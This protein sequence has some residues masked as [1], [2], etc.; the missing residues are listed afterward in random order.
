MIDYQSLI[1]LLNSPADIRPPS[2]VLLPRILSVLMQDCPFPTSASFVTP[3]ERKFFAELMF[4]CSCQLLNIAGLGNG[5]AFS[6]AVLDEA[7]VL[8]HLLA[9]CCLFCRKKL[10]IGVLGC[11][12]QFLA[13]NMVRS[14]HP[15]QDDE[16]GPDMH[17]V[18][19]LV[20]HPDSVVEYADF[21]NL[22]PSLLLLFRASYCYRTHKF[23][24]PTDPSIASEVVA[25]VVSAAAKSTHSEVGLAVCL[26]FSRHCILQS[27]SFEIRAAFAEKVGELCV[28]AVQE[29]DA[30][31]ARRLSVIASLVG[32]VSLDHLL[33]RAFYDP[34]G[35]DPASFHFSS[36]SKLISGVVHIVMIPDTSSSRN[37]FFAPYRDVIAFD[38][39]RIIESHFPRS[40]IESGALNDIEESIFTILLSVGVRAQ[41]SDLCNAACRVFS[42]AR[43]YRVWNRSSPTKLLLTPEALSATDASTQRA[44]LNAVTDAIAGGLV[45]RRDYPRLIQLLHS[46]SPRVRRM[47]VDKIWYLSE[48]RSDLPDASIRPILHTDDA[49]RGLIVC[50]RR[51][52]DDI[53]CEDDPR[54]AVYVLC[55][56]ILMRSSSLDLHR[57]LH[58]S[59]KELFSIFNDSLGSSPDDT[60]VL[61][62]LLVLCQLY[63]SESA[64]A[65][66]TFME[67]CIHCLSSRPSRELITLLVHV[68]AL[69]R[70]SSA[71]LF[72]HCGGL[73]V[74]LSAI[75]LKIHDFSFCIRSFALLSLVIFDSSEAIN[76]TDRLLRLR[77]KAPYEW[78]A[79]M[80]DRSGIMRNSQTALECIHLLSWMLAVSLGFS[81]LSQ[82]LQLSDELA[83]GRPDDDAASLSD[84]VMHWT[85][86]IRE[87][88]DDNS[89]YDNGLVAD[90]LAGLQGGCK[91]RLVIPHLIAT[92]AECSVH[93][94]LQCPDPYLSS[95]YLSSTIEILMSALHPIQIEIVARSRLSDVLVSRLLPIV[96]F[97]VPSLADRLTESGVQ[98]Q[99][100]ALFSRFGRLYFPSDAFHALFSCLLASSMFPMPLLSTIQELMSSPS[101]RVLRFVDA[102]S[103]KVS[104]SYSRHLVSISRDNIWKMVGREDKSR[105]KSMIRVLDGMVFPPPPSNGWAFDCHLCLPRHEGRWMILS[106]VNEHGKREDFCSVAVSV[107]RTA[108]GTMSLVFL[109]NVGK[110]MM[111]HRPNE[112]SFSAK[113]ALPPS[114]D[115]LY[116]ESWVHLCVS[117]HGPDARVLK[118]L[119]KNQL[120]EAETD[121]GFLAVHLDGKPLP[122]VAIPY[123]TVHS[124]RFWGYTSTTI[125]SIGCGAVGIP[126]S[127]AR[128]YDYVLTPLECC[129]LNWIG[130]SYRGSF[131]AH[132]LL[133]ALSTHNL[134]ND[135]LRILVSEEKFPWTPPFVGWLSVLD[136]P[137]VSLSEKLSLWI[138]DTGSVLRRLTLPNAS[139]SE[140]GNTSQGVPSSPSKNLEKASSAAKVSQGSEKESK[141]SG[142]PSRSMLQQW[143]TIPAV[144]SPV[145]RKIVRRPLP[146]QIRADHVV[147]LI[148][149]TT[150]V[151]RLT[152]ILKLVSA[153][154][155]HRSSFSREWHEVQGDAVLNVILGERFA[156]QCSPAFVDALWDYCSGDPLAFRLVM[157]SSNLWKRCS[158]STTKYHLDRLSRLVLSFKSDPF[159]L[160]Q[161]VESDSF[162]SFISMIVEWHYF[163]PVVADV[164]VPDIVN[165]VASVLS[166][167]EVTTTL[168]GVPSIPLHMLALLCSIADIA[169][170]FFAVV[171]EFYSRYEP[172]SWVAALRERPEDDGNARCPALMNY[173]W[174]SL[175]RMKVL[176]MIHVGRSCKRFQEECERLAIFDHIIHVYATAIQECEAPDV[177]MFAQMMF[178]P[179]VSSQYLPFSSMHLYRE[180]PMYSSFPSNA[181]ITFGLDVPS[182][183]DIVLR[184]LRSIENHQ[185]L[186]MLVSLLPICRDRTLAQKILEILRQTLRI[187]A[188]SVV[189]VS[190]TPVDSSFFVSAASAKPILEAFCDIAF[191]STVVNG[192]FSMAFPSSAE[193]TLRSTAV[194]FLSELSEYLIRIACSLDAVESE[195]SKSIETLEAVLDLISSHK[196]AMQPLEA[197]EIILSNILSSL[198][199]RLSSLMGTTD[200]SSSDAGSVPEMGISVG[201]FASSL[202]SH[203]QFL[204]SLS[205]VQKGQNDEFRAFA[206]VEVV[207]YYQLLLKVFIPVSAC[208]TQ[209]I[210][211]YFCI[212]N[213]GR[214][215]PARLFGSRGMSPSSWSLDDSVADAPEGE[216]SEGFSD[217]PAL[218]PAPD[219]SATLLHF[220]IP[221]PRNSPILSFLYPYIFCKSVTF[222]LLA[223]LILMCHIPVPF[224][225][226]SV[227]ASMRILILLVLQKMPVSPVAREPGFLLCAFSLLRDD[228]FFS[229]ALKDGGFVRSLMYYSSEVLIAVPSEKTSEKAIRTARSLWTRLFQTNKSFVR[230]VCQIPQPLLSLLEGYPGLSPSGKKEEHGGT[231]PENEDYFP[232]ENGVDSVHVANGQAA[233]DQRPGDEIVSIHHDVPADETFFDFFAQLADV[234]RRSFLNPRLEKDIP[235]YFEKN[236]KKSALH[237]RVKRLT[238]L[239]Q[240]LSVRDRTISQVVLPRLNVI[241]TE[242]LSKSSQIQ[243]PF[244][245]YMKEYERFLSMVRNVYQQRVALLSSSGNVFDPSFWSLEACA[246]PLEKSVASQPYFID[247]SEGDLRAFPSVVSLSSAR[248]TPLHRPLS[249]PVMHHLFSHPICSAFS[250]GSAVFEC[251]AERL[252]VVKYLRKLV[253]QVIDTRE[254]PLRTRPFIKQHDRYEFVVRS[255]KA[256]D[257]AGIAFCSLNASF[258]M[259]SSHSDHLMFASSQFVASCCAAHLSMMSVFSPTVVAPKTVSYPKLSEKDSRWAQLENL[260]C[261]SPFNPLSFGA[262]PCIGSAVRQI[263]ETLSQFSG[264]LESFSL[265]PHIPLANGEVRH[266]SIVCQMVTPAGAYEGELFLTS[267]RINFFPSGRVPLRRKTQN[268]RSRS[269]S[270]FGGSTFGNSSFLSTSTSSVYP[271]SYSNM[272]VN[273]SQSSPLPDDGLQDIS[274]LE[275]EMEAEVIFPFYS[276]VDDAKPFV[277]DYLALSAAMR[278]RH[279]LQDCAVELFLCSGDTVFFSFPSSVER[280][281]VL[282]ILVIFMDM[283]AP[284]SVS[285]FPSNSTDHPPPSMPDPRQWHMLPKDLLDQVQAF[286]D[287]EGQQ[288]SPDGV[289][290]QQE[291]AAVT[292]KHGGATLLLDRSSVLNLNASSSQVSLTSFSQWW[293]SHNW[294]D[295]LV[296]VAARWCAG[297]VSNWEYLMILNTL[298][299]RSWC[300]PTQYPVLPHVLASFQT[301]SPPFVSSLHPESFS[302]SAAPPPPP[303][304]GER[305]AS[306][307]E[308]IALPGGGVAFRDLTRSM[309][310]T[311]P[312]RLRFFLNRFLSLVEMDRDG[313]DNPPFIYGTHYMPRGTTLHYLVRSE[314]HSYLFY[315]MND[316]HM[317]AANRVFRSMEVSW[318]SASSTS[319]SEVRE[320]IPDLFYLWE[321]FY[322]E[323]ALRIPHLSADPDKDASLCIDSVELPP[324]ARFDA[325]LFVRQHRAALEASQVQYALPAWIDLMWGP[326]M[327]GQE[328]LRRFNIFHPV[329]YAGFKDINACRDHVEREAVLTQVENYGQ[330]P[331]QLF[332]DHHPLRKRFAISSPLIEMLV[333][334][335][336]RIRNW[337]V[338]P[339]CASQ[340]SEPVCMLRFGTGAVSRIVCP[341]STGVAW[342]SNTMWCEPDYDESLMD[343]A[344]EISIT[345]AIAAAT[346]AGSS[347]T[348]SPS[349]TMNSDSVKVSPFKAFGIPSSSPSQPEFASPASKA[350]GRT[351]FTTDDEDDRDETMSTI[352]DF[353]LFSAQSETPGMN[354]APRSPKSKRKSHVREPFPI[355]ALGPG[356]ALL[357]VASYPVLV[358]DGASTSSLQPEKN[359]L[360]VGSSN[361]SE[362]KYSCL[363]ASEYDLPNLNVFSADEIVL[364]QTVDTQKTARE[365]A[366]PMPMSISSRFLDVAFAATGIVNPNGYA[367]QVSVPFPAFAVSPEEPIASSTAALLQSMSLE[368]ALASSSTAAPV[369]Y[370]VSNSPA[371]LRAYSNPPPLTAVSANQIG[372]SSAV[373]ASPYSLYYPYNESPTPHIVYQGH[374]PTHL[375]FFFRNLP[376]VN[377]LSGSVHPSIH[378][379]AGSTGGR[380]TYPASGSSADDGS[381]NSSKEDAPYYH[382]ESVSILPPTIAASCYVVGW[383]HLNDLARVKVWNA[384]NG[385]L[386]I[387]SS[388]APWVVSS[389]SITCVCVHPSGMLL[390]VGLAS[391]EMQ[392]YSVSYGSH[393]PSAISFLDS[394]SVSCGAV[395][396]MVFAESLYVLVMGTSDGSVVLFDTTHRCIRR[397]MGHRSWSSLTVTSIAVCE[398]SG[399]ICAFYSSPAVVGDVEARE[400]VLWSLN[401][402]FLARRGWHDEPCV[403]C[404][405]FTHA[406]EGV[407]E[408]VLFVGREDGGVMILSLE[409]LSVLSELDVQHHSPIRSIAVH[410]DHVHIATGDEDGFVVTWEFRPVY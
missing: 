65:K 41:R 385:R 124:H 39:L 159:G 408:N 223:R 165:L 4:E 180:V 339:I 153:L 284:A 354:F 116:S 370:G 88:F 275:A 315:E 273:Q 69:D 230:A 149:R 213:T 318:V 181:T 48:G 373:L 6:Q 142:S 313:A 136:K 279:L 234:D 380:R 1:I 311:D 140:S 42:L 334:H 291:D 164:L 28:K 119:L 121:A 265:P 341:K 177:L 203:N 319:R 29:Q 61:T 231:V 113:V 132:S 264:P 168:P 290:K 70:P 125:R 405:Q 241:Y 235:K 201:A 233:G 82:I 200:D 46:P 25:N 23:L 38:I 261:I 174:S 329:S 404:L 96:F 220:D 328:A 387:A 356:R 141:L 211:E 194:S 345:A 95:S 399:E 47:V 49:I 57:A 50:C 76:K 252:P 289:P 281:N 332:R 175:M 327:A 145:I 127:Q 247:P 277:T 170:L 248:P 44:V 219:F 365:L 152:C 396:C 236:I 340:R 63:A 280:E 212:L 316:H 166:V 71:R 268:Q 364:S 333:S 81:P 296:Q 409:D 78:V 52:K 120:P 105:A 85:A 377:P 89:P 178:S 300:D 372:M 295:A 346:A 400:L 62:C 232:D 198:D 106:I 306:D 249:L 344:L 18:N 262:A 118:R 214:D 158:T 185:Q 251:C 243:K 147:T 292:S 218:S 126:M 134:S 179:S 11:A 183:L 189:P 151:E 138:T 55:N 135:I 79:P 130:P 3:T 228:K 56:I 331:P 388:L 393:G 59:W 86:S 323:N 355:A 45:N 24:D 216:G 144:L 225:T 266:Y 77:F 176:E 250:G 330:M 406:V 99:I 148:G 360:N 94:L 43:S 37:S 237:S 108:N 269:V 342:S 13:F 367:P 293:L 186:R 160:W 123:P 73:P 173:T 143:I 196:S 226:E 282:R 407:H 35:S 92:V 133:S 155:I 391:G 27:N 267:K 146:V 308:H 224:S 182:V 207:R 112:D 84:V 368:A 91:A 322:N 64:M 221:D 68:V 15:A 101:S 197:Q 366:S 205:N 403:S 14:A 317:D 97:P 157:F 53:Q 172:P 150:D 301:H 326:A 294:R 305:D 209:Y 12:S 376:F 7:F 357:F 258:E 259:V 390:Y 215:L 54:V 227:F 410:D 335:T 122:K 184:T 72:L 5:M 80:F 299:G 90:F 161:W 272:S 93:Y 337:V 74:L 383:D 51:R 343:H 110:S 297:C 240:S 263:S 21:A 229:F 75:H 87:H 167:V 26:I 115:D 270:T 302:D 162:R 98:Q 202:P 347:D 374:V 353:S 17:V 274:N 304:N 361:G 348:T 60:A 324:W 16:R 336:S 349:K 128:L 111:M 379:T 192:C 117:H 395:S 401:G 276:S 260:V 242:H 22:H 257:P 222:S 359:L 325:R 253:T 350:N 255:C 392:I 34:R 285:S 107:E 303:R 195:I 31:T 66:E 375:P 210:T 36:L 358:E 239:S 386:V 204:A 244:V 217:E 371:M 171:D 20:I 363:F 314:P 30:P 137:L 381:S 131:S 246:H 206:K 103:D 398:G 208:V 382:A 384:E 310:A 397:R 156:P 238:K 254:G 187:A 100:L 19:R 271:A 114:L 352:S 321:M 320:Q 83:L 191:L 2:N 58:S 309:G 286:A 402:A 190:S 199:L 104:S 288:T 169:L 298:A 389:D 283:W 9:R 287:G 33:S 338:R 163:P 307:F 378:S 256:D 362:L 154:R 245:M 312:E 351:D 40:S 109:L 188:A 129:V 8:L 369:A 32:L 102:I 193:R 67:D 10:P 394:F 139:F 278:R